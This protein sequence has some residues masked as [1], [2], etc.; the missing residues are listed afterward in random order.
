M[1]SQKLGE[2]Q[3]FVRKELLQ[4]YPEQE[5]R[6]ILNG[7]FHHITGLSPG[8]MILEKNKMLTES[9]IFFL[10][11]TMKRLAEHEPLQY[12]TGSAWFHGMEFKVNSD[13]LIPRPET[14]E[15]IDWISLDNSDQD[16]INILDIGTGSACIAISLKMKMPHS[17]ILAIDISEKALKIAR[18]NAQNMGIEI[19]FDLVNI[20]DT[21]SRKSLGSFDLVV[22]NPPY[23]TAEDREK[24]LPNVTK[25]EPAL[26]LFVDDDPLLFYRE[27]ITFCAEHLVTGG[28]L[29]F[30]CNESYAL[31]V[32]D[33]LKINGYTNVEVRKDMQ[34][35]E[36]MIRGVRLGNN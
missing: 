35:K 31:D 27:I 6:G 19:A 1:R 3:D 16:P 2:L 30:E 11:R 18:E 15:L 10:Q 17:N 36:R 14:E 28:R 29:Y 8:Q 21:N 12:I 24:M 33:L 20:L 34:G 9:E 7:L 26:A 25:H 22:S 5:L 32:S 23:V 13:V 4:F